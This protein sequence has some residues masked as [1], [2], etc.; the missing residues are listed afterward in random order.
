MSSSPTHSDS[1]KQPFS[2]VW[3]K[4]VRISPATSLQQ[5]LK[6]KQEASPKHDESNSPLVLDQELDDV[7]TVK[8]AFSDV[9]E[10]DDDEGFTAKAR[11]NHISSQTKHTNQRS[12]KRVY[13]EYRV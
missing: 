9:K 10:N 3:F 7:F 8:K 1:Q 6:R 12:T 2:V 11:F 5:I 13:T 4:D